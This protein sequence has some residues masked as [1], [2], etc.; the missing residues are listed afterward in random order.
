MALVPT[1]YP[2]IRPFEL[3]ISESQERMTFAVSPEKLQQFMDLAKS[4]DVE[5]TDLGAFTGHGLFEILYDGATVAVLDMDFLHHG[6]PQMKLTAHFKGEQFLS[7]REEEKT[8]LLPFGLSRQIEQSLQTLLSSPNI[9]SKEKWVRQYDHE[10][11]AATIVKPF[12]GHS[13]A[14]PGN[15]AVLALA[16]P[17]RPFQRGHCGGLWHEPKTLLFRYLSYGPIR[18]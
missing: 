1:K 11:Q 7:F 8:D 3:V 5:A 2:E 6:L 16:S 17:W 10:V 15:A 18:C 4:Y 9:A 14:G 12:V 13:Q